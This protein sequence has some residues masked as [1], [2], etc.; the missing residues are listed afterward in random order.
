ML[1]S[2][3]CFGKERQRRR[4]GNAGMAVLLQIYTKPSHRKEQRRYLVQVQGQHTGSKVHPW[5]DRSGEEAAQTRR[6]PFGQGI[7]VS[8]DQD[9]YW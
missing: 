4:I 5:G 3:E 2:N 9:C 6:W 8:K 1:D 7:P